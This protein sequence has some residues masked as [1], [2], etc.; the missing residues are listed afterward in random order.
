MTET[1]TT[2]ERVPEAPLDV[3]GVSFPDGRYGRRRAPQRR[4]PAVMAVLMAGVIV[5]GLFAAWRLTELHGQDEISERLL[6][7]DDSVAGQVDVTFEVYKP[8]GEGAVC[9]VRS[10]DLAGAE[11]GYAEVALPAD[12][13]TYVETTYTLAV[14]GEPNTGEVL[15][16]WQAD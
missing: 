10:R 13:R 8:A 3:S 16:C 5:A 1:H 9:A 11:I 12:E 14:E 15:R 2:V 7:F 4:R 6:A